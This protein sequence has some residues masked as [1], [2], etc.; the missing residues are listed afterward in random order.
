MTRGALVDTG[1]LVAL[2]SK[3]D[4]KH[5]DCVR[6]A[7]GFVPPLL[8]SW[9]VLTEVA[10]LVRMEPIALRK[11]LEGAHKGLLK[12]LELDQ[13][14]FSWSTTFLE[15]YENI[16]VQLADASLVY[17]AEREK[18]EFIFTLDRRDFSV[19]R[20]SRNRALKIIPE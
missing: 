15:K 20:T 8:T 14:F 18:I 13:E 4:S 1:P 9:P 7:Q 16:G 17:L 3:N 2:F 5:D 6:A 10:W 11:L 19:Y 12:V